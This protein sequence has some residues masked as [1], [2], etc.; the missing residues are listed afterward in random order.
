MSN[1]NTKTYINFSQKNKMMHG[2]PTRISMNKKSVKKSDRL[3]KS[4]KGVLKTPENFF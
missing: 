2:I 4:I 3:K 1:V